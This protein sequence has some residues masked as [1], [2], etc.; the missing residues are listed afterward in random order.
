MF[1]AVS[2]KTNISQTQALELAY[3]YPRI[4]VGMDKERI[5]TSMTAVVDQTAALWDERT[6]FAVGML[7][8]NLVRVRMVEDM[9]EIA[10]EVRQE[11]RV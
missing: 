9:A 7:Q 2:L 5:Q 10:G 8:E 1:H 11:L 6:R 4:K 3:R